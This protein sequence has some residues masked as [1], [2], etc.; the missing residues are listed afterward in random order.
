MHLIKK[1]NNIANSK[2]NLLKKSVLPWHRKISNAF[3]KAPHLYYYV[4]FERVSSAQL[5]IFHKHDIF[6]RQSTTCSHIIWICQEMK[7]RRKCIG[8][9]HPQP[10]AGS[11]FGLQYIALHGR[12]GTFWVWR[13]AVTQIYWHVTAINV[14]TLS[15]LDIYSFDITNIYFNGVL[16]R[17]SSY[18]WCSCICY[19]S[20]S[21]VLL[22]FTLAP[23]VAMGR[24]K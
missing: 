9:S 18:S 6:F 11:A 15:H 21:F 24:K 2:F 10:S 7:V 5:A 1:S 13:W 14:Y 23:F 4:V 19:V 16:P 12:Y 17:L 3:I 20:V 8:K 22:S